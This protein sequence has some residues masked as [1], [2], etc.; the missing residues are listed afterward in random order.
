MTDPTSVRAELLR[1]RARSPSRG[2][3]GAVPER[4]ARPPLSFAQERL[5]FLDRLRPGDT[6][7][8]VPAC[9]RLRGPLS[10]TAL[11]DALTAVTA[12]HE[13][14]RTRIVADDAEPWQRVV[15]A[16]RVRLLREDLSQH[17]DPLAAAQALA[18][19]EAGTP[20]QLAES[21]LFRTR[22]LAIAPDDH[23]LCL[24]FHHI[25]FDGWSLGI[26]CEDLEQAYAASSAGQRPVLPAPALQP[27]DLELDQ[28]R[29]L[30]DVRVARHLDHWRAA[31]AGAPTVLEVATDHPRPATPSFA[32]GVVTLTLP[33][34]LQRGVRA[35]TERL[36]ATPYAIFLAAY[37]T[38][39]CR[40]A[41]VGDL[42]VG[43]P[44]SGRAREEAQGAVGYFVNTVPMRGSISPE[45][46]F[47]AL[48]EQA[49]QTTIDGLE[50]Q[51]LPFDRI[52]EAIAPARDLT[53]NPL[54]QVWLN[55]MD[56]SYGD[57]D[58]RLAGLQVERFDVGVVTTRFELELHVYV[59]EAA[60]VLDLVHARSL[61]EERSAR[62]FLG[63][64]QAVLA[65]AVDDPSRRVAEIPLTTL[66][67]RALIAH[68]N[69]ETST[70]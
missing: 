39:L 13:A 70:R 40:H 45:T 19:E 7:Y 22:L 33:A 47:A 52:V 6:A 63:H 67:E 55:V 69:D 24:T 35:L 11:E 14:L 25:I 41:R 12:R 34:D 27:I 32:A 50:H 59:E 5:W 23:L 58:L 20:F 30:D 9:F 37:Q 46:S 1:R 43:S 29:R 2:N 64:L 62:W 44:V 54:V 48:V 16:E 65:A 3:K 4:P 42:V 18:A 60:I 10:V 8:V 53:R 66:E 49:R 57:A 17:G 61:F 36:R 51:E 28:R 56:R 26:V 68:W 31:L 21:P 38:V 15:P